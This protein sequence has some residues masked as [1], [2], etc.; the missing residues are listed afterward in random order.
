MPVLPI[1]G[2]LAGDVNPRFLMR[3]KMLCGELVGGARFVDD[4]SYKTRIWIAVT[5]MVKYG[6][7]GPWMGADRLLLVIVREGEA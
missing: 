4:G 6:M 5:R 1:I 7:D 2:F 3:R